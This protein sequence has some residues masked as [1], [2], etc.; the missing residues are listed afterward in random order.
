MTK[1]LIEF[2]QYGWDG[3]GPS[4][5]AI[6]CRYGARASFAAMQGC[7]AWFARRARK[8]RLWLTDE[9]PTLRER[10]RRLVA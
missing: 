6:F 5:E 7:P 10:L 1:S 9:R 4:P 8:A 2:A 3:T